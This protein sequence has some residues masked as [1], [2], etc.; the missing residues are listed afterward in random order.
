MTLEEQVLTVARGELGVREATGRNDGV[1]ARRYMRGDRLPWCAGLCLYV[2]DQ[3]GISD[4]D[5]WFMRSVANF[6]RYAEERGAW[7]H[8]SE[9]PVPADLFFLNGRSRSDPGRGRHMGVVERVDMGRGVLTTIEG[10]VSNRCMRLK[11]SLRR[12]D[13][14]APRGIT[15]YCRPRLLRDA[16]HGP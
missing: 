6:E 11:R 9:I 3:V 16:A 15:G 10:N 1:P 2:L 13:A 12:V 14:E 7:V 8:P 4:V 5:Y